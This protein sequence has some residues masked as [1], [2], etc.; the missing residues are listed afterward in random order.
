MLRI[1]FTA[2][3]L[4][5]KIWCNEKK[6]AAYWKVHYNLRM[7]L[8]FKDNNYI[9]LGYKVCCTNI[10]QCSDIK[11]NIIQFNP[12][13][14]KRKKT[15]CTTL[16]ITPLVLQKAEIT[17]KS[18][19]ALFQVV[20]LVLVSRWAYYF[21]ASWQKITEFLCCCSVPFWKGSQFDKKLIENNLKTCLEMLWILLFPCFL[22]LK[23][24]V[25]HKSIQM[26]PAG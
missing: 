10:F 17:K 22:A 18:W 25:R 14:L 23:N 20:W 13:F 12:F 11:F 2:S 15:I 4:F 16:F 9:L 21:I 8:Y 24:S 1:P 26:V 3:D 19:T 7:S 6:H 5:P